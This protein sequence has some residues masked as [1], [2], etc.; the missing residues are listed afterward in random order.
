MGRQSRSARP[1]ANKF[2]ID[3]YNNNHQLNDYF[4]GFTRE[5]FDALS[6]DWVRAHYKKEVVYKIF[7]L[8]M[9]DFPTLQECPNLGSRFY[10]WV[11]GDIHNKID[12]NAYPPESGRNDSPPHPNNNISKTLSI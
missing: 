1:D 5:T 10:V 6:K 11:L 8:D 12:R 9:D 2:V 4:H 7:N 3:Q